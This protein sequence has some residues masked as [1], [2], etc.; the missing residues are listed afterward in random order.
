MSTKTPLG[1]NLSERYGLV[2]CALHWVMAYILL[3]QFVMILSWKTDWSIAC[4]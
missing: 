4:A 1:M 3:W 2:S